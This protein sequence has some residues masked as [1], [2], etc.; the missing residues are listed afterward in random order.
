M[1]CSSQSE[2]SQL[3]HLLGRI[4]YIEICLAKFVNLTNEKCYMSPDSYHVYVTRTWLKHVSPT[5]EPQDCENR[6][7]LDSIKPSQKLM[8]WKYYDEGSQWSMKLQSLENRNICQQQ[9]IKG[10][11]IKHNKLHTFRLRQVLLTLNKKS[12]YSYFFPHNMKSKWAHKRRMLNR[13]FQDFKP[14]NNQIKRIYH[15]VS[16]ALDAWETKPMSTWQNPSCWTEICP[17]YNAW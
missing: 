13:R 3:C 10:Y 17:T 16:P 15:K 8:E 1:A 12:S 14:E 4:N 7:Y 11:Y 6:S 2:F 5:C 9:T